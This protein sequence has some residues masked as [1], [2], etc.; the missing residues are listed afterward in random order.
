[1][2]RENTKVIE[3]RDKKLGG[4][5]EILI[6]TMSNIKTSKVTEVLA[7][8]ADLERRGLDIFRVSIL[9]EDDLVAL[10]TIVTESN[11]PIVAD[12]HFKKDFALKAIATGVDKI[13]L[14]PGNL[15]YTELDEVILAAKRRNTAIRIGVNSGSLNTSDKSAEYANAYFAHLDNYIKAFKKHDYTDR[16]VIAL[17]STDPLLTRR[18]NEAAA[19][20]YPYPIHIGITETGYGVQGMARTAVGLVPLLERGIG[21]TIRI[22]LSDEPQEEVKAAKA[23][24]IAMGLRKDF[25]TLISCPTCGRT[26]TNVSE[27]ARKVSELLEY[28]RK[29]LKVAV[30]GCP[31]NGPGEAKDADLGLAGTKDGYLAFSNGKPYKEMKPLDAYHWLKENIET[32]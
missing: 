24:L 29:P 21:N 10:K 15:S 2:L 18:L 16:L 9:D 11:I 12:I 8:L 14:N 22:S 20:I 19:E 13:R 30:M 32:F 7:Q 26:M 5:N 6:Q 25:P 31:V 4:S 23:L 1:M 3:L 28:V 17:K 27:M